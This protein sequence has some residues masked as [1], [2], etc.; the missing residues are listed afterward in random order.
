LGAAASW[1]L[2]VARAL[3]RPDSR[4]S[5]L[6]TPR[7][8]GVDW[9]AARSFARARGRSCCARPRISR[10]ARPSRALR[11]SK[12]KYRRRC[13]R[14]AGRR[15]KAD[16]KWGLEESIRTIPPILP[17][18]MAIDSPV[19]RSI[20]LRGAFYEPAPAG[21]QEVYVSMVTRSEA[22]SPSVARCFPVQRPPCASVLAGRTDADRASWSDSRTLNPGSGA[23]LG[24]H[25][26]APSQVSV[27]HR[28]GR[29]N[30]TVV[31]GWRVPQNVPF[32]T[33]S[34]PAGPIET[35][36]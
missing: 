18:E 27:P 7:G 36:T 19:P 5:R 16:S 32:A 23:H 20:G 25:P 26:G 29:S 22:C 1:I 2:I 17:S 24:R 10:Q 28:R 15:R 34:T 13:R 12:T 21:V 14:G 31:P 30:R 33:S 11:C 6:S 3:P 8:S 4:R 35:P 9:K